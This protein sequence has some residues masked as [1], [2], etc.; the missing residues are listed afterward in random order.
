M[1]FN[2]IQ[3]DLIISNKIVTYS[4]NCKSDYYEK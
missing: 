4:I 3:T 2:E 1:K